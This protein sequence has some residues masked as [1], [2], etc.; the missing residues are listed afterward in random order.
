[1]AERFE[2]IPP[3]WLEEQ[4]AETIHARMMQNLPEDI[5]DTEGG[6]PWDFTKP[7]ALEK[8]E[9]LE[10]HMMETTKV[11]HYMFAYGIYLDW[12][13]HANRLQRKPASRASGTVTVT[14]SPGT[15]IPA[16]FLFAVPAQGD[17]AAI[18]FSTLE[19]ATINLDG[20]ADITVQATEAGTTGN[21]AADTVVIMASPT[22]IGINHITNQSEITGGSAEESDESLRQRIAEKLESEEASFVGCDADYKRWAK[23]VEGVGDEVIVIAEWAGPGT[24]KIIV[25]DRNGLPANPQIVSDVYNHIVSPNDRDKRL[26]T[27]GATVTVVAPTEIP[28]DVACNIVFESGTNHTEVVDRI[29][30]RLNAYFDQTREAGAIKRNKI[31]SV[32]IGTEGV[33][34]Y[35]TLLVNGGTS[36]SIPV[37]KDEYPVLG[38]LQ[39]EGVTSAEPAKDGEADG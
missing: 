26:A 1:M 34:D 3:P 12:H 33:T 8:A 27:I 19:E 17:A 23:E 35:D 4:D 7:T 15:V 24:V 18:T 2:F 11:M 25:F 30:E 5:D 20:K 38:T 37:A 10:F 39:T 31:G 9:L 32:I 21:V 6:F 36:G 28:I 16:G 29:K 22:I 13:A 14:G